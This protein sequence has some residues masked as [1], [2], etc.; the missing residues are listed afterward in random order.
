MNLLHEF[1]HALEDVHGH[2]ATLFEWR[3][4][5][6]SS[7]DAVS[8]Q[9]LLHPLNTFAESIPISDVAGADWYR[10][11]PLDRDRI[12]A[13]AEG[14]RHEVI[15]PRTDSLIYRVEFRTLRRCLAQWFG[16]HEEA[17]SLTDAPNVHAI[18]AY[19]PTAGYSYPALL[20]CVRDEQAAVQA[21]EAV[22][23]RIEGPFLIVAP[24]RRSITR[25]VTDSLENRKSICVTLTEAIDTDANGKPVVTPMFNSTLSA[26][27]TSVVPQ[28][29]KEVQTAFFPTPADAKWSEL[30]IKFVD[31]HTVTA[32]IR[33]VSRVL[34]YLDMGLADRRSRR[35][36]KQWDLLRDF[37]RN[38]GDL[39]WGDPGTGRKIQ[40]RKI[41]L[42]N[43]LKAFFR[44][45]DEPIEYVDKP[46][47]GWRTVFS[48]E[49]E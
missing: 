15:L 39:V 8:A 9:R 3:K 16:F 47:K 35:P 43:G 48:I 21:A 23:S 42:A 44:I 11:L 30:H 4:R 18:G 1:W 28:V 38:Y 25:R 2:C 46:N 7:F 19:R 31:G 32:S 36:T 12:V 27:F 10:V 24:T 20:I 13:F 17:D 37:S 26:F 6:G 29:E 22:L 14:G 41:S 49:R 34:T 33:D 40:A 5:L 45:D